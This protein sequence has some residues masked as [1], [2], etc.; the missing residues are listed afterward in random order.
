M[1]HRVEGLRRQVEVV[2]DDDRWRD[3]EAER[4]PGEG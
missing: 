1:R 2:V 4:G 3:E